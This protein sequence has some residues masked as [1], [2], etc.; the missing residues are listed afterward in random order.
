MGLATQFQRYQ[1]PGACQG[2]KS[3][4][5]SGR[6]LDKTSRPFP[7]FAL[8]NTIEIKVPHTIGVSF[9]IGERC[10]LEAACLGTGNRSHEREPGAAIDC[11]GVSGLFGPGGHGRAACDVLYGTVL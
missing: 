5:D 6:R 2:R 7:C 9:C 8:L 1:E 4:G 10:G 11:R 3:R